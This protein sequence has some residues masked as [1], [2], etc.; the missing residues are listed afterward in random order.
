MNTFKE[1]VLKAKQSNN[2]NDIN[3]ISE[4]VS[5]GYKTLILSKTTMNLKD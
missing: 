5:E 4:F 1:Q 2:I 3:N